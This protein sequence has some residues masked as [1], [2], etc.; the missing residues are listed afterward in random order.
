MS[1]V[2]AGVD[3]YGDGSQ[4]KE[5]PIH[6]SLELQDY[7]DRLCLVDSRHIRITALVYENPYKIRIWHRWSQLSDQ[8][9]NILT[10]H[11]YQRLN[12]VFSSDNR[13]LNMDIDCY[14]D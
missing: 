1:G 10:E 3:T 6:Y 12:L 14:I 11:P 13:E 8:L 2:I 7:T 4:I 5:K 9:D